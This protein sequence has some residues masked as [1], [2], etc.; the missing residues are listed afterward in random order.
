MN[1]RKIE[2]RIYIF[3]S[4]YLFQNISF[5]QLLPPLLPRVDVILVLDGDGNRLAGKYY[6]DFLTSTNSSSS[7][8]AMKAGSDGNAV[9]GGVSLYDLRT[10]FERQ[11]QAKIQGNFRASSGW[12]WASSSAPIWYSGILH[13]CSIRLT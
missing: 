9:P 1:N 5:I 7:R 13:R 12:T 6:G 3:I 10:S 11:L 4:D 8:A 2:Q